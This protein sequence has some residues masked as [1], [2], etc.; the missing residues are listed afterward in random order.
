MTAV[1]FKLSVMDIAAHRIEECW[2]CLM[3]SAM[4]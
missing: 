4:S 1:A 2:S 3:R